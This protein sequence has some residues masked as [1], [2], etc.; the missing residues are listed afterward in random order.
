MERFQYLVVRAEGTKIV[1][2][3]DERS[4][5]EG[6]KLHSLLNELGSNG[7]ELVAVTESEVTD[8]SFGGIW[9]DSHYM[10]DLFLKRR[11]SS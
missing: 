5:D 6:L 7:W 9:G 1:W 4:A 10:Q 2:L 3:S 11:I 8:G